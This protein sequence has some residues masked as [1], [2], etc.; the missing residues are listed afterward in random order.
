MKSFVYLPWVPLGGSNAPYQ[1]L[2]GLLPDHEIRKLCLEEDMITPFTEGEKRPGKISYGLSHYGYDIRLGYKFK[3]FTPTLSAVVDPKAIDDRAFANIDLSPDNCNMKGNPVGGWSC[4]T[5]NKQCEIK[6]DCSHA[7]PDYILIPPNSYVL[8]ES[9]ET[10]NMPEDVL[11]ICLG[12]STLARVALIVNV[13]PLEPGWKGKLTI[14]ISNSCQL[15][16]KLYPGEG[17][18]QLLFFRAL[19]QCEKSYK[20]KEGRYQNQI[21]LQISKVD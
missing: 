14:E 17:V 1:F 16:V 20:S 19:S 12:K 18:A 4:V 11:S 6:A 21:G 10:F 2:T 8:G 7:K 5:C 13:T 15:P 3:I 9:L